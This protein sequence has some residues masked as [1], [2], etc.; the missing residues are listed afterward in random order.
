MPLGSNWQYGNTGSNN[1]LA[2]TKPQA[3]IWTNDDYFTVAYVRH[4][5]LT[6]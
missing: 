6:T 4:S 2:P 5:A 1:G 3:I